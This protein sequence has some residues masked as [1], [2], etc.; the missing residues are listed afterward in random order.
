MDIVRKVSLRESTIHAIDRDGTAS[1]A[2]V[3]AEAPV[4][5]QYWNEDLQQPE[6]RVAEAISLTFAT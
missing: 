3:N 2:A 1:V 4:F 5:Y 6:R